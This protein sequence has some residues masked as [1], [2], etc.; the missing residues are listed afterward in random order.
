M[1]EENVE[2]LRRAY[3][4][5]NRRDFDG[6]VEILHPEVEL[7]PALVGPGVPSHCRGREEAKAYFETISDVWETQTI[8]PKELIVAPDGR[9]LVVENWRSRG[10]DGIEI[11]TVMT[12]V[13]EFRDGLCLRIEGF[14]VKSEALE[15]AGLSE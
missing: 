9:V 15:A 3:E 10:R 5:F 2:A 7:S 12:D 11:D 13:Y 8:E 14:R 4:A 6:V 1:S